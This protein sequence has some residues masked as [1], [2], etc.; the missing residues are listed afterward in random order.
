MRVCVWKWH[1]LITGK[2]KNNNLEFIFGV[3][4]Q[5][6]WKCLHTRPKRK[7]RVKSAESAGEGKKEFSTNWAINTKKLTDPRKQ[8]KLTQNR[9]DPKAFSD[10]VGSRWVG[11]VEID[12]TASERRPN[13][14]NTLYSNDNGIS[15]S[16]D[17][18]PHSD[19]YYELSGDSVTTTRNLSACG[20][21][22]IFQEYNY[23][24]IKE[25]PDIYIA[26]A[27]FSSE[28]TVS[29]KFWRN[30]KICRH[31][32]L[33]APRNTPTG[34]HRLDPVRLMLTSNTSPIWAPFRVWR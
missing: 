18:Q 33:Y 16:V 3:L 25:I 15:C 28:K 26:Y 21:V 6:T 7:K 17:H 20:V 10:L 23:I 11:I 1:R 13:K 31:R 32:K 27:F 4:R 2:R 30:Y 22:G 19:V 5:Q 34:P 14:R 12:E 8:K 24:Y 29:V 9:S